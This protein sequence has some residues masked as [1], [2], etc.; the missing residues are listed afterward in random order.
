M[1][2]R[3]CQFLHLARDELHGADEYY[4]FLDLVRTWLNQGDETVRQAQQMV[5]KVQL[6]GSNRERGNDHAL[7][8]GVD[9]FLLHLGTVLPPGPRQ[10]HRLFSE[11]WL[12]DVQPIPV[13]AIV[14]GNHAS[15]GESAMSEHGSGSNTS[16]HAPAAANRQV[17]EDAS[18]EPPLAAD[19]S[20]KSLSSI[21]TLPRIVI[22]LSNTSFN[23]SIFSAH[24]Q[25]DPSRSL[26]RNQESHGEPG[27]QAI[28]YLQAPAA[29]NSLPV[30][31]SFEAHRGAV[32]GEEESKEEHQ[33]DEAFDTGGEPDA[34]RAKF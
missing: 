9:M 8:T 23:R 14:H 17:M 34:K 18:E 1:P 21:G 27:E 22:D 13:A 15:S 32:A 33:R 26:E 20:W 12:Q 10:G 7:L 16:D 19:H 11:E 2:A 29:E 24:D 4:S 6:R 5:I 25:A 30:Q 28:L 3:V 31:G